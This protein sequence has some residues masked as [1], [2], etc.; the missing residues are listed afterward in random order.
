MQPL[1]A[2]VTRGKVSVPLALVPGEPMVR[3]NP[4]RKYDLYPRARS[5]NMEV[6]AILESSSEAAE[7]MPRPRPV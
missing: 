5:P 7:E 4:V 1:G 6:A 3:A 2:H